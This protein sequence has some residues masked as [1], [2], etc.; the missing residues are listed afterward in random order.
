MKSSLEE[1]LNR[2]QWKVAAEIAEALGPVHELADLLQKEQYIFGDLLRHLIV[3]EMLIEDLERELK[4]PSERKWRAH[5]KDPVEYWKLR[6]SSSP[7]LA[8][9]ANVQRVSGVP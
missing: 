2:H 7:Q 8:E 5:I 4:Q 3:C 9:L 6:A 1:K